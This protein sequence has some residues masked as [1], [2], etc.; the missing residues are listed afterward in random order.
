MLR[1]VLEAQVA[2][3]QMAP[4][5]VNDLELISIEE[6]EGIREVW[7][8]DK[9]EAEDSLPL[10]YEQVIG[11]AYPGK[12]RAHHPIMN[13]S[14]L[15]KLKAHCAE[16]GDED[17]LLYQQMRAVLN[18]SNKYRNQ[19]RRAKLKDELNDVLDKGA[20]DNLFEAKNS[21]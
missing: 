5:E 14:V 19:L 6:L 15:D 18:V 9:H 4:S 13:K 2:V 21:R 12:R 16:K 11:K 1:K 20:F 17:G 10:I 8:N 3:Q 7:L